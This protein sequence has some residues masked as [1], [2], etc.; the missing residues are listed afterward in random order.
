MR[1][2]EQPLEHVQQVRG[3]VGIPVVEPRLDDLQVPVAELRPEERVE[4]EHAVGEVVAVEGL[5]EGADLALQPRDDPA[6]LDPVRPGLEPSPHPRRSSLLRGLGVRVQ[7]D[8]PRGVPH[9]VRQ[10]A[11]LLDPVRRVAHVLRRGHGQ[12]AEA[13]RVGAVDLDLVEG[14][15]PGAERLRHPASVGRLDDRGDVDVVERPLAHELDPHHHHP[16]DPEEEDVARRHQRVGGIERVQQRGRLVGPAERR[17]RPQPRAE[18]GVEHVGVLGQPVRVQP[19]LGGQLAGALRRL[20]DDLLAVGP[21]PDRDP[22]APPEL[23]RDAPGPDVVHPVEVDA[24]VLLGCD[25]DLVALDDLD[26]RRRELV[27][28]AEPLQRDQRLDPLPGA[29]RERHRVLVRLLVAQPSFL[30]Q[31]RDHSLAGLVRESAPRTSPPPRRSS[32]RPRR[33]R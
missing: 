26:R 1:E 15:D 17:E 9:L 3:R 11:P 32:A 22:V 23:A 4:A 10:V 20:G 28:A 31:R 2:R 7:Q 33:S 6:V 16:R 8:Q 21:V 19:A 29:M 30:T 18:P 14:V 12:E 25:P 24:L 27:H 5:A 13:Q